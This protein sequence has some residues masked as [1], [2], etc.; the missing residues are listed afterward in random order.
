MKT[1]GLLGALLLG[2]VV[3]CG[4]QVQPLGEVG[5]AGGNAAGSGS[6]AFLYGG[7]GGGGGSGGLPAGG[8]GYGSMSDSGALS[9]CETACFK[10]IVSSA[11][12]NCKICHGKVVRLAGTLDLESSGV[13]ARLKDAF[14]QHPAVQA[15][16]VCPQGDRLIDSA[17]P[18][19]SWLLKK[20]MGQQGTC[21]D[22]M[23]PTDPLNA[24]DKACM[25]EFVNCVASH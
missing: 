23:P 9:V 16:G 4:G 12:L 19:N 25:T 18:Q 13:S 22:V 3:A 24:A 21:G 7:Y 10:G 5:G 11:P 17:A 6:S 15:G 1:S 8:A 2:G 14:A 20:I